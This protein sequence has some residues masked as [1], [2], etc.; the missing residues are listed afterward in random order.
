MHNIELA[1]VDVLAVHFRDVATCECLKITT[2]APRSSRT[3]HQS[4]LNN[5][6][7]PSR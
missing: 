5:E 7:M 6:A 1:S 4:A 2:N 3:L